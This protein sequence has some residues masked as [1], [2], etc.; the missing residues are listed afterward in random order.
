MSFYFNLITWQF[1]GIVL[2]A[3]C[4]EFTAVQRT[5]RG[6]FVVFSFFFS[7]FFWL[8]IISFFKKNNLQ[9]ALVVSYP[10]QWLFKY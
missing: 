4:I 10:L 9:L 2:H 8:R 1:C 7:F 6:H 3:L 5:L